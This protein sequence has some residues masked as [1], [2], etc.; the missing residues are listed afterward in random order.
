MRTLYRARYL[1]LA[2]VVIPVLAGCA[3]TAEECDPSKVNNVF[4]AAGCTTFGGFDAHL[5]AA[6]NELDALRV[7]AAASRA[8]AEASEKE[9]RR[10]VGNRRALQQKAAQEKRDVDRLRL[11]LAAMRVDNDKARARQQMMQAELD[12]AEARASSLADGNK[13]AQEIAALEAEIA[14]RKKAVAE[15][16]NRAMQ[17]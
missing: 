2:A 9:A 8:L 7:E 15:L 12:T 17:E 10:L 3:R 1:V 16:T 11:R 6:R 4:A 14:A 13:T 5:A